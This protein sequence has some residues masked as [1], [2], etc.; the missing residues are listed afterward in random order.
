MLVNNNILKDL[1]RNWLKED[2]GNFDLTTQ[3]IVNPESQN[4]F[5]LIARETAVVSGI[6]VARLIFQQVDHELEFEQ[7]CK[8]KEKV[9]NGFKMAT[10]R[11]KAAAVL[12]AERVVL[13][14]LQRMCGIATMTAK[15]VEE[16]SHTKAF[17]VDTRKTTPGLRLIE[18][19]AFHCGG[20][21]NHRFGLDS[22]VMLK[23]NHIALIGNIVEAIKLVKDRVP[24]LTKIEVECDT[25]AQVKE[26]LGANA[27]LIMLDNMSVKEMEIAVKL[28]NGKIP[29]ECSGGVNISN[30]RKKAETG[31]N[32]ISV[33][34]ITQSA[35]CIDIGLDI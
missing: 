23:D 22:G 13:N 15:F 24:I 17:L 31:V 12:T 11:G 2:V 35:D 34:M 9:K 1:I 3:L 27:D 32:Y 30:I 25:L 26:A 5:N 8:D 7:F 33:G 16:I 28:V 4:T 6:E 20:G 14:V 21:K 18:K 10:I 19:H 29:L